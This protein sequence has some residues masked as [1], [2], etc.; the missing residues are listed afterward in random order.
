MEADARACRRGAARVGYL[1]VGYFSICARCDQ[2]GYFLCGVDGVFIQAIFSLDSASVLV[3]Q[4]VGGT[5]P[6]LSQTGEGFLLQFDNPRS[7]LSAE[8]EWLR[9]CVPMRHQGKTRRA[10][11]DRSRRARPTS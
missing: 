8:E 4:T 2:V 1:F 5:F 11:V 9:A 6:S 7:T 10:C 3:Y